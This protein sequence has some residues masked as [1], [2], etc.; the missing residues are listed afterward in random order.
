M[1]TL[2]LSQHCPLRVQHRQLVTQTP[3]RLFDP[4]PVAY[5]QDS[6]P[7]HR[8]VLSPDAVRVRKAHSVEP[9]HEGSE[10][11]RWQVELDQGYQL[12]QELRRTLE[13]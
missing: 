11:I 13:P 5:H 3:Q 9:L 6:Q 8:E 12:T 2:I 1:G 7:I 4:L 10:I